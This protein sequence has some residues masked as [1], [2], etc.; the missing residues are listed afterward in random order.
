MIYSHGL[1][2]MKLSHRLTTSKAKCKYSTP[3]VSHARPFYLLH[4]YIITRRPLDT[5]THAIYLNNHFFYSFPSPFQVD[6]SSSSRS[7]ST[8]SSRSLSS[9]R[10]WRRKHVRSVSATQTQKSAMMSSPIISLLTITPL[11]THRRSRPFPRTLHC[12]PKR[13]WTYRTTLLGW[14]YTWKLIY[15]LN[16]S[17]A[18]IYDIYVCVY[19]CNSETQCIQRDQKCLFIQWILINKTLR[20]NEVFC[21]HLKMFPCVQHK[22]TLI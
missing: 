6:D 19:A 20:N 7:T 9:A 12:R 15:I 8:I 14:V 11:W 2:F 5:H 3:H 13:V 10:E 22:L 4:N 16:N 1:P 18:H 21:V 17:A